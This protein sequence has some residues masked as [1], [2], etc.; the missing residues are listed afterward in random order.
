MSGIVLCSCYADYFQGKAP[1]EST[2][3]KHYNENQPLLSSRPSCYRV[4]R[5]WFVVPWKS[6]VPGAVSL[7]LPPIIGNATYRIFLDLSATPMPPSPLPSLTRLLHTSSSSTSHPPHLI[8]LHISSSTSHPPH[9]ILHISS[10]TPHPPPHLI[11]HTSSFTPPPHLILHTSLS[12]PHPP[13]LTRL[14]YD[15]PLQSST[16]ILPRSRMKWLQHVHSRPRSM[17]SAGKAY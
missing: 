6:P 3:L 2:L 1:R 8:L 4:R 15:Q 12:T 14:L 7:K 13:S 9:L 5:T 11:L 10:S 17:K 16:S